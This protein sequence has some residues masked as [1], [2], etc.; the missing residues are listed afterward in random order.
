MRTL[1]TSVT[2]LL[3]VLLL[4]AP[5][6]GAHH[7]PFENPAD[8]VAEVDDVD[9]TFT[10]G[11]FSRDFVTEVDGE[12]AFGIF[13]APQT[14]PT[15]LVVIGHGA[16]H[17][18]ESWRDHIIGLTGEYDTLTVAMEYRGL[19]RIDGH[20]GDDP[21]HPEANNWPEKKGG[22]D[23][24]AAAKL[25]KAECGIDT[26]ILAGVSMGVSI[27]GYAVSHL[28]AADQGLFDYWVTSEGVHSMLETYQAA[29]AAGSE[30]AD[31]IEA[32]TGCAYNPITCH[33]PYAE[34]T[35][36]M[37]TAAIEAAGLERV[38]YL[39]AVADGLVPYNQSRQMSGALQVPF[40]FYTLTSAGEGSDGTSWT[41]YVSDGDGPL[42][43]HASE[44][45]AN[46]LLTRATFE[47]IGAIAT[48]GLADCGEYHVEEGAVF[49][50][51][52]FRAVAT[53]GCAGGPEG[54]P[55]VAAD[56]HAATTDRIGV[57]IDVLANDQDP[58]T[59][60]EH[61]TITGFSQP[62]SGVVTRNDDDTLHYEPVKGATGS[63]SF[64]YTINDPEGNTASATVTVDVTKGQSGGGGVEEGD[65]VTGGGYLDPTSGNKINF[66]FN[67]KARVDGSYDGQ[68]TMTDKSAGVKIRLDAVTG[69]DDVDGSCGEIEAGP[70]AVE[71]TGTGT[72][73]SEP[74]SFRVCVA[75]EGEPGNSGPGG[76]DLFFLECLDGCA[77]STGSRTADDVID[78]GN[79][80]VHRSETDEP[81]NGAEGASVLI[82][83]PM[84]MTETSAPAEVFTVAA[85]GN[86]GQPATGVDLTLESIQA[87]GTTLVRQA[88]TDAAGLALFSV[89]TITGDVEHLV[90]IGDLTSNTV[91]LTGLL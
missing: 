1:R 13:A 90:R 65:K 70:D 60:R 14:T 51:V 66:G 91:H 85:Y 18:S 34:R 4:M 80:Q 81:L 52:E 63:F 12:R 29:S 22:E 54:L 27:S 84:L 71:F 39:H 76:A 88:V 42:A 82:L 75:D 16:W 25:F 8:T 7:T 3:A 43:G 47:R 37:Q 5:A 58:D 87:D 9:C 89:V 45:D 35:N 68:L 73:N 83:D 77:F 72:F 2:L 26:V 32:E 55:P 57:D 24:I 69:M 62:E 21:D 59:D 20:L 44:R 15:A 23:L 49:P 10:G 28:D 79:I 6:A 48:G 17:S 78:G 74:A 50:D 86:D 56:D 11:E 33:E 36:I 19:E 31:W 61:L 40:E 30:A 64:D 53:Y 67:V 46:S 41:D 38:V